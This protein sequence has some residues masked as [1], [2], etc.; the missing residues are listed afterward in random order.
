[1]WVTAAPW[2]I[3]PLTIP[4]TVQANLAARIDRLTPEAKRL[5]YPPQ[6]Q[7][8]ISRHA[9]WVTPVRRYKRS[10]P[11]AAALGQGKLQRRRG[12]RERA[13][14]HLTT[15]MAMYRE[16]LV[17]NLRVSCRAGK[18]FGMHSRWPN[19]TPLRNSA[20]RAHCGAAL[21]GPCAFA[22]KDEGRPANL[23]KPAWCWVKI[24]R[25]RPDQFR[26]TCLR[27]TRNGDRSNKASMVI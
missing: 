15:A 20:A 10:A 4:A 18:A 19:L 12:D 22:A 3:E 11:A 5:P 6:S 27:L 2:S 25:P 13:L 1:M 24:A 7:S 14:E 8:T 16:K 17:R 26:P 21:P 23:R 9:A